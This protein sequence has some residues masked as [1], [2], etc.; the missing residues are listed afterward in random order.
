MRPE[1][2]LQPRTGHAQSEEVESAS[3]MWQFSIP[4]DDGRSGCTIVPLS[5]PPDEPF[6]AKGTL[7]LDMTST[8]S[9]DN[10]WEYPEEFGVDYYSASAPILPPPAPPPTYNNFQVG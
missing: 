2:F 9:A 3:S 4:K 1:G 8:H 6:A 7:V 5:C 10:K